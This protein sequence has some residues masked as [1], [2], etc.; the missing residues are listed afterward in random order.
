VDEVELLLLVFAAGLVVLVD[1]PVTD[2]MARPRVDAEGRDA[3][4]VA[5]GVPGDTAVGELADLV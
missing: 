1:D 3:E 5:D 2:L 4:V